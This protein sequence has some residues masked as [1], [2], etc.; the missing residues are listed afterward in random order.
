M[1]TS[2][3][4]MLEEDRNWDIKTWLQVDL[5]RAFGFFIHLRDSG[6]EY[7]TVEQLKNSFEQERVGDDY[8][9]KELGIQKAN[10]I[11]L[12]DKSDSEWECELISE[13]KREQDDNKKAIEKINAKNKHYVETMLKLKN[14]LSKAESEVDTNI[15]SMAIEQL[16]LCESEFEN[17]WSSDN[18]SEY[19]S[20]QDYKESMIK[21]C[22]KDIAKYQ[23]K[24]IDEEKRLS[25]CEGMYEGFLK[26]LDK[27][28]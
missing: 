4:A 28:L 10:L 24:I 27:Y 1:P 13:R 2:Y 5:V 11:K 23:Q 18:Y 26:F 21:E 9:K 16:E 15:V 12:A 14:L 3:T 20:W 7:E 6:G 22:N 19:E 17:P 25:E 8:Y